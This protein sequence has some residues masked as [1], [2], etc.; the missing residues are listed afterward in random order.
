MTASRLALASDDVAHLTWEELV[1]RATEATARGD[2]REALAWAQKAAAIRLS[3]S[4]RVFMLGVQRAAGDLAGAYTNARMCVSEADADPKLPMRD[5]ILAACHEAV[6]ALK[7]TIG[8]LSVTLPSPLPA[9][10]KVSVS[11]V[12]VLPPLLTLPYPVNPG[13]ASVDASAP[14]YA[15]FHQQVTVGAA[16][17]VP[18]TVTLMPEGPK[19]SDGQVVGSDH[20]TCV[21]PCAL[22]KTYTVDGNHCCWP[23]QAWSTDRGSCAGT[24]ECP[25][26]LV[27]QGRDCA[28][29]PSRLEAPGAQARS[30]STAG[31]YV[32]GAGALAGIAGT[33]AWFVSD[34]AYST[35]KDDCGGPVQCTQTRFDSDSSSVKTFETL[36]AVGWIAGGAALAGGALWYVMSGPSSTSA[37]V[38]LEIDPVARTA[39]VGGAF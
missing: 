31:L 33:I 11:G 36:A 28:A 8:E 5:K 38:R 17:T 2:S 4:L 30:R 29:L 34:A 27:P 32:A 15:P 37:A 39:G 12:E 14:G 24:P 20:R 23:G 19:C 35:L 21:S 9:A 26:G 25:D 1:Q 7:P 13:Q 10:I 22:G 16:A 18:V 6:A 3:P